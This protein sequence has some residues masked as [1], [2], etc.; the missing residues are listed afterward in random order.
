MIGRNGTTALAAALVLVLILF[1]SFDLDRPHRGVITVPD[2]PLVAARQM[3]DAPPA[4]D[5]P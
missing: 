1:V 4:A 2:A 3:M 5:G